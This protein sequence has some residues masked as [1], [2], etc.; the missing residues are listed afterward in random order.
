MVQKKG[1]TNSVHSLQFRALKKH[2]THN[3]SKN[4]LIKLMNQLSYAARRAE[5]RS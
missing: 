5:K 3:P 4:E 1:K 2:G